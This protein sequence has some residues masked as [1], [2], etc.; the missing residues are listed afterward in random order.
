MFGLIGRKLSHSFSPQ[1]HSFFG[2]Y[3]YKLWEMEE[4][5]VG[6]FLNKRDFD[7]INVTIPYKKTVIPYLDTISDTAKKIGSVNTV[8]KQHDGKLF[9]DNTDYFGFKY[10]LTHAINDITNKKCIILG[11]GG[12]C[13][14]VQHVL[15]DMGA[16]EIVIISRSGDNNYQNI[17][18]HFNADIII[19]TT[20]VGMY[21]NNG[22]SPIDLTCF[23]N[24]KLVLDLIYNPAKTALILQAEK[25]GI[26]CANG[27]SMLVAQGKLASDLFTGKNTDNSIIAVVTSTLSKQMNNIVLI[28][29]PG[30][31]KTTVGKILAQKL[32][33][34]F[35]DTDEY[36][37]STSGRTPA[38]I[39]KSDGEATFRDI[40]QNAIF[41]CCKKNS[42]VIATGG[43]AVLRDENIDAMRQNGKIIFLDRS[44]E[45]LATDDRPLSSSP[46]KLKAI[47]EYRYPLYMKYC[48]IH[49]MT[50]ENIDKTVQQILTEIKQ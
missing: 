29:M 21:P 18:R 45:R 49:I 13:L 16:K 47:F 33:K 42:C 19:N 1:I 5:D 22:A 40:E 8:I 15:K 39:I 37:T 10:M 4:N 30:C 17:S 7:G 24:C 44:I 14:T 23:C 11:S 41:E 28:G 27:L 50:T 25:L 34:T 32:N 31:G 9:G 12:A 38:E 46:D 26:K 35:I 48:D 36:I 6:A 3:E 2:N 43:G 20:P